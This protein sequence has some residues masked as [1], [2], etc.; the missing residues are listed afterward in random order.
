MARL[1]S[2]PKGGIALRAAAALFAAG[3]GS[4]SDA[5]SRRAPLKTARDPSRLPPAGAQFG[6][7]VVRVPGLLPAH[8]ARAAAPAPYPPPPRVGPTR[9]VLTPDS[10]SRGPLLGAPLA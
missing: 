2:R 1:G 10:S 3:C 6:R 9:V 7:N 4:A 8:V 5:G